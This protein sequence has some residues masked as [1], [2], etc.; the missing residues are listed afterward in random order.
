MNQVSAQLKRLSGLGYVRAANLPGRNSYYSVAE[1][2]F[3]I[4]RQSRF[5]REGRHRVDWLIEFL[6]R[7]YANR[8]SG[9]QAELLGDRLRELLSRDKPDLDKPIEYKRY[10]AAAMDRAFR[11]SGIDRSVQ[12]QILNALFL[13]RNWKEAGTILESMRE[14][15][16]GPAPRLWSCRAMARSQLGR[17]QEALEDYDRY[18]A[19]TPNDEVALERAEV[20]I[21][22]RRYYDAIESCDAVLRQSPH[23]S[24]A[25]AVRALA[26][27]LSGRFEEAIA[28]GQPVAAERPAAAAFLQAVGRLREIARQPASLL[29]Y[30]LGTGALDEARVVWRQLC[31]RKQP[32]RAGC[33]GRPSHEPRQS[34]VYRVGASGWIRGRR[35][36]LPAPRRGVRSRDA[37]GAPYGPAALGKLSADIRPVVQEILQHCERSRG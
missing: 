21:D 11:G 26:L 5:G 10:L 20:L 14:H 32:C 34:G 18:L 8:E 15:L 27:A 13:S 3:A 23:N 4:W 16:R 9:E 31:L 7:W 1:P 24:E 28:G 29:R 19:R 6:K 33:P 12:S 36:S 25:H 35:L 17:K 37:L 22:L 30:L 2:L